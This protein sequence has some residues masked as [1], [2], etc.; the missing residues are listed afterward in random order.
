M[1][2]EKLTPK[3]LC[4]VKCYCNKKITHCS[5]QALKTINKTKNKFSQLLLINQ[6][7]TNAK[8]AVLP[9]YMLTECSFTG[10]YLG[11]AHPRK[12][13]NHLINIEKRSMIISTCS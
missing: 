1:A 5:L 8:T 2:A 7:A 13:M 11:L 4:Y 9:R 6:S 3:M 10:R 12:G